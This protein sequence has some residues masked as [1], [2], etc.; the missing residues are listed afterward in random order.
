MTGG[1]TKIGGETGTREER[2]TAAVSRRR[3]E[4][5]VEEVEGTSRGRWLEKDGQGDCKYYFNF[6]VVHFGL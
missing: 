5:E 3:G 2:A 6:Y 1:G 4:G